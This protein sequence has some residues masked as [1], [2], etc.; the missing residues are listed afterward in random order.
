MKRLLQSRIEDLRFVVVGGLGF[1]I[2]LAGLWIFHG[3]LGL[4]LLAAQLLAA[5][6]ALLS[7]F[8]LHHHWTYQNYDRQSFGA[9]LAKFHATAWLGGAITSGL[10]WLLATRANVQ[11]LLALVAGSLVALVWNYF[12]NKFFIWSRRVSTPELSS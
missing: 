5:E 7:N 2:N 9:R 11:Y 12:F 1:L 8:T 10:T 6:L 3:R 4:P